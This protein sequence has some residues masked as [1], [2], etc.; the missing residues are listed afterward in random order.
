MSATSTR[1]DVLFQQLRALGVVTGQVLL[2]HTAFSRVGPVEGGALGVIASLLEAVGPLGTL[3]MP[4]LTDDENPF[5]PRHTAC[6]GMGVVADTFW[7]LPGVLRSDSPHVFA[8]IGPK[9]P[10]I[11]ASHPVEVPHGPD[12]PAG[13]VHEQDAPFLPR[14][15]SIVRR[16]TGTVHRSPCATCRSQARRLKARTSTASRPSARCAALSARSRSLM[17]PSRLVS[18]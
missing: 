11:T 13:R 17:D 5:D 15:P 4:S 8:A 6:R 10:E 16:S 2:V 14:A 9:A 1:K 3:V 12:S 7:R 18:R